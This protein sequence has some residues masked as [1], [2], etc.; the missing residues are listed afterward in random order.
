MKFLNIT[1]IASDTWSSSSDLHWVCGLRMVNRFSNKLIYSL[2]V[3]VVIP[4][5]FRE[6]IRNNFQ[7]CD[8]QKRD[9]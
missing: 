6:R 4:E 9:N 3:C 8:L 5:A 7:L 2:V 1:Q